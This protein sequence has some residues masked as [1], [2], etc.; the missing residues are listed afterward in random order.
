MRAIAFLPF[1]F[2]V[3]GGE[4]RVIMLAWSV[5]EYEQGILVKCLLLMLLWSLLRLSFSSKGSVVACMDLKITK[6]NKP[7]TRL[8]ARTID[9]SITSL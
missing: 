3:E 6:Q 7:F 1:V 8:Q 4:V 2:E 9:S 5:Y